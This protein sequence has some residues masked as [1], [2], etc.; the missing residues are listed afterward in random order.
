MTYA[1]TSLRAEKR[2]L[3]ERMRAMGLGTG[4]IAAELARRFQ[5]RPRAAWRESYGWSLREAAERIN[6]HAG[7]T[8]LDPA[9]I[10]AMTGAH[11]CEYEGWPGLGPRPAGRRP[12]LALLARLAAAYGCAITDL[13]DFRD[14]E[15]LPPG[16]ILVLDGQAGSDRSSGR[17]VLPS[18]HGAAELGPGQQLSRTG[19][20]R[21]GALP[22]P[23]GLPA[24]YADR[25][26]DAAASRASLPVAYSLSRE[27]A[28]GGASRVRQEVEMAAH[29]G[30]DYA[31]RAEQRD[32]GDATLEQFQADVIRLSDGYMTAE[33]FGIFQEM[34]RVR[35]RMHGA[36]DRRLWPRDESDL[37]LLLGCINCLMACAADDLGYP[38]ASEELIR[39][40]WAYAVVID[41]RPLMAKLRGDLASV[42]YW[43]GRP[44]Q[45][46]SL[47]ESGLQYL[48]VGPNA[49]QL[50]LKYARA[51][52][53]AGDP[54]GARRAVSRSRDLREAVAGDDL[55]EMGG[56]FAFSRAS[57]SCLAGSALLEIPGAESEAVPELEHAVELYRAGPAE[58]EQHGFGLH[59][60]AHIGL[61]VA[62]LRTG[63]LDG[64]RSALG[65]V[66]AL[67]HGMRIDPL[68][69]GLEMVRAELA[70]PRYRGSPEAG[71]LAARI[72][73]FSRE[74]VVGAGLAA[75]PG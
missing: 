10:A 73:D 58:G 43:H 3:L 2:A 59:M 7:G 32:I 66:L 75:L 17:H 55:L 49:A 50:H 52:A 15:H 23:S 40:A 74:S 4:D 47:A 60:M 18:G 6:A 56:E 67:P 44:G 72:E 37:Y 8:G 64:A 46:R 13:V 38:H 51:S 70:R 21:R 54:D 39:A 30:S 62:R 69:Q 5:I 12:T 20:G 29:D 33:P 1:K 57:L 28:L 19:S 65:L 48:A 22:L 11:L 63:E 9:G 36:L 25:Q 35:N 31:E 34:R 26:P 68:P 16:D 71:D 27:P 61:A 45:A 41:H 14:R 24:P 53:R 42:A